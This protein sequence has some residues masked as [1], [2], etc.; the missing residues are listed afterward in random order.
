M[1]NQFITDNSALNALKIE[2]E[3]YLSLCRPLM[4]ILTE[5][6]PEDIMKAFEK[7][8]SA[9]ED[10][11]I[12]SAMPPIFTIPENVIEELA[13]KHGADKLISAWERSAE[14]FR[15]DIKNNRI[16]MTLLDPELAL[17]T[18]DML[19][20]PMAGLF[21][22]GNFVFTQEQYRAT[23]QQILH[24]EK[25]FENLTVKFSEKVESNKMLYVKEDVGGFMAKTDS[26]V[27]VFTITERNMTGSFWD[28]MKNGFAN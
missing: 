1:L 11:N 26:P 19:C 24:L 2:Y 22:A 25:E 17:L 8:A 18:P 23:V 28:Y 9:D 12:Y 13:K 6:N 16:C 27:T 5:Q 10:A 15:E 20:P 4:R 7:L 3:R 14:I 21:C